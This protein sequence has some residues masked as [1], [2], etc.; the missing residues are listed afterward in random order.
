MDDIALLAQAMALQ[1]ERIKTLEETVELM[2]AVLDNLTRQSKLAPEAIS[3][4][5]AESRKVMAGSNSLMEAVAKAA[6][7]QAL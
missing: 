3:M 4:T 6:K 1:D 7:K 5:G 2:T